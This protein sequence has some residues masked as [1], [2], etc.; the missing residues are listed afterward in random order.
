M[1]KQDDI[2]LYGACMAK[3]RAARRA[4]KVEWEEYLTAKA[5]YNTAKTLLEEAGEP[6][7]SFDSF[8]EA[9]AAAPY[10]S[11]EWLAAYESADREARRSAAEDMKAILG[12]RYPGLQRRLELEDYHDGNSS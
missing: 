5:L 1:S 8:K 9:M 7:G 12:R 10:G 3:V 11:A 2:K 6:A 4:E